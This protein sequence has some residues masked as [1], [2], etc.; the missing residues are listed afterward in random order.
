MAGAGAGVAAGLEAAG[1]ASG[2]LGASPIFADNFGDDGSTGAF[3]AA[4]GDVEGSSFAFG[5]DVDDFF[6][7]ALFLVFLDF[8]DAL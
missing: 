4:F 6:L 8:F 2:Y 3:G 7:F 1:T 5:A